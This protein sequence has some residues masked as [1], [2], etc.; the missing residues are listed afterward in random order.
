MNIQI[1]FAGVKPQ[2]TNTLFK[3]VIFSLIAIIIIVNSIGLYFGNIL[4]K[5]AAI[6]SEGKAANQYNKYKLTFNEKKFERL[7]KRDITLTSDHGYSLTGTY[8]LCNGDSRNTVIL[9]HDI[10]GSRWSVMKY[11]DMY[12]TKGFNVLIYDARGHGESGGSNST[13]GYFEKDDLNSWVEYINSRNKY[14]II[15][16]HGEGLGAFT[17]LLHSQMNKENK[18]VRFYVLDSSFTDV[19]AYLTLKTNKEL[20]IKNPLL[21]KPLTFYAN[22]VNLCKS[23]FILSKVSALNSIKDVSTPMLF[24][25]GKSDP[26]IPASM[27]EALFKAKKD[28]KQLYITNTEAHGH[29]YSDNVEEYK[30]KV[31]AF[32]DSILK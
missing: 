4:L 26:D 24:I 32:I 10:N 3:K 18:R 22:M 6:V 21:V 25:H 11:A 7:T 14:G 15:G 28:N 13:L 1:Q 5:K 29:S 2:K 17:A 8:I 16:V 23:R 27:T 31:T 9:V 19:Q 12:L 30:K 20:D